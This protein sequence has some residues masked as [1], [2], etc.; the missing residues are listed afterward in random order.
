[1]RTWLLDAV[2]PTGREHGS[3][4]L[5]V[6]T[7]RTSL[8]HDIPRNLTPEVLRCNVSESLPGAEA[9]I[10]LPSH[11]SFLIRVL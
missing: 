9:P 7:G 1:M 5:S 2:A 10:L 4:L 11:A 8:M 6:R 3:E